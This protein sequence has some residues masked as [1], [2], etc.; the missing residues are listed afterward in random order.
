MEIGPK[1]IPMGASLLRA[2]RSGDIETM[3]SLLSPM[4][5]FNID[6]QAS[7]Q[8]STLAPPRQAKTIFG[9]TAGGNTLLHVAAQHGQ[10]FIIE[11]IC[12]R[13]LSLVFTKNTRLDSPLHLAA[14]SGNQKAAEVIIKHVRESNE[15]K[16]LLRA[17]N[18]NG[19]TALHEAARFG[20]HHMVKS[21]I[22]L[23]VEL[24]SIVNNSGMSPLYLAVMR[25]SQAMVEA[26]LNPSSSYAGPNGQ[27]ALHAARSQET[28][29]MLLAWKPEIG[30][31]ADESGSLPLHYLAANGDARMVG[32]LLEHDA[33][34][35]YIADRKGLFPVHIAASMNRAHVITEILK[36]CPDSDELLDEKGRSFLHVSVMNH[37][38]RVVRY[39]L[40]VPILEKLLNYQDSEGNTPL[41]LACKLGFKDIVY[42]LIK[43]GRTD[44]GVMNNEGCTPLDLS[45]YLYNPIALWQIQ[46]SSP[47]LI[48]R[49]LLDAGAIFSPNRYDLQKR[50]V[51]DL[52]NETTMIS[53]SKTL[54]ILSILIATVTFTAGFT[55]PGGYSSGSSSNDNIQEGTAIL[56]NKFCFKVFLISNTL[57]MVCSLTATCCLVHAGGP[58]LDFKVRES[59]LSWSTSILWLAFLGM[60]LAFGMALMTVVSPQ[61]RVIGIVVCAITFGPVFCLVFVA[62][63]SGVSLLRVTGF[64]NGMLRSSQDPHT[65]L[66][67]REHLFLNSSSSLMIRAVSWVVLAYAVIFGL[68]L[69]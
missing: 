32:I 45:F 42:D 29:K 25:N 18:L 57:A 68:A 39:V 40:Q 1:Q 15:L 12:R 49:C 65:M 26:L 22:A 23:D 62:A 11:E 43:D 6:I 53:L 67:L 7:H 56:S 47:S 46:E 13:E 38:Q 69:F 37:S 64:M 55:V 58:L 19:D 50:N 36:H 9:V 33:F 27:T 48:F 59:F 8:S 30:R 5:H 61:E 10:L 60:Y 34:T 17:K 28:A 31:V 24:S 54:A 14:R 41:H 20:N 21:F 66:R 16:L 52:E 3:T 63:W 4:N 51:H 44:S 2:A 35:S